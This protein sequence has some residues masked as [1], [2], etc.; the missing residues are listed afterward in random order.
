M[1]GTAALLFLLT[2]CG[3]EVNIQAYANDGASFSFQTGFSEKATATIKSFAGTSADMPLFT[4]ESIG[5]VLKSAGVQKIVS[6]L[7]SSSEIYTSGTI[8]NFA[9]GAAK[10]LQF[11]SRTKNSMTLT[12]GPEQ[13]KRLYHLVDEESKS[14]LDLLM[15]PALTGEKLN[16]K[17]Y[18]ELLESVYGPDLADEIVSGELKITMV[19][20]NGKAKKTAKVSLGELLTTT[21]AL[22]WSVNW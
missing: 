22:T 13:I 12:L 4:K 1:A 10:K 5:A 14:Y 16:V 9:E 2:S 21:K 18:K 6:E 11:I 20:Q 3:P 19:S 17:D 15:I 7:P 8:E